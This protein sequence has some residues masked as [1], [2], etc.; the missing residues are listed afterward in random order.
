MKEMVSWRGV[1]KKRRKQ[2]AGVRLTKC[3]LTVAVSQQSWPD[4]NL[5]LGDPILPASAA[6]IPRARAAT[7]HNLSATERKFLPRIR[8]A[9]SRDQQICRHASPR[10][11]KRDSNHIP[12]AVDLSIRPVLAM[13]ASQVTTPDINRVRN[14]SRHF[15]GP[16]LFARVFVTR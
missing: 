10:I 13:R 5:Y 12:A 2:E 3:S 15:C 8:L 4:G 1:A 7:L 16:A 11:A 6:S 9:S 14:G